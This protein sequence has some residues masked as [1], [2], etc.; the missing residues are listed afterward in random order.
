M[1][2]HA[3]TNT[4][5]LLDN[6]RVTAEEMAARRWAKVPKGNART[7]LA[8]HAAAQR[9]KDHVKKVKNPPQRRKSIK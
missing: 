3:L 4:A 9:W 8:K 6:A 5:Y 2:A 1:L 7:A